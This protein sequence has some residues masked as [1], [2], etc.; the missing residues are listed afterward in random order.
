M[1]GDY[2]RAIPMFKRCLSMDQAVGTAR[3]IVTTKLNLADCYSR[4][5]NIPKSIKLA[6]NALALAK[7][8][9]LG[10]VAENAL[11]QL[12]Q[13]MET[14]GWLSRALTYQKE[15]T[16]LQE[17][18]FQRELK[19]KVTELKDRHRLMDQE[20]EI[21]FLKQEQ[22]IQDLQIGRQQFFI[23]SVIAVAVL[24]ALLAGIAAR[25][26]R[27]KQRANRKLA[28]LNQQL[29][30]L[31]R[32]DILTGLPNRRDMIDKLRL[33]TART[34]R[35]GAPITI[36]MGDLDNFKAINDTYGHDTG[37]CVLQEV[38][39]VLKKQTRA[40][41]LLARWGG[42][43]FLIALAD[44]SRENARVAADKFRL[45]VE[46]HGIPEKCAAERVTI[47]IGLSVYTPDRELE[48]VIME[49]D[50]RLYEGK[51]AGRNRVMG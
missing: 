31:A 40:Q 6:Q 23:A 22:A 11:L 50:D 13:L 14:R 34:D 48:A 20:T 9:R 35:S 44:T 1:S 25:G 45:A 21:R 37:D 39:R 24:L 5:G 8:N 15:L 26:Y 36:L 46:R 7:K 51:K 17:K 30:E 43:E 49:A 27:L 18:R 19:R 28:E 12:I 29:D 38:A 3:E 2:K 10:G 47:T 41:D 42:E 4:L 33:F 32:T 16:E